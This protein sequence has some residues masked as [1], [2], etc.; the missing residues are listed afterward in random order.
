MVITGKEAPESGGASIERVDPGTSPENSDKKTDEASTGVGAETAA[1]NGVKTATPPRPGGQA[2]TTMTVPDGGWGAWVQVACSFVVMINTW[3]LINS[4]GV[5]Q[6][7]YETELLRGHSSS[8]ISWVGSLQG[9]L[10]LLLGIVSGPLF[11][12]GNFRRLMVGGLFL[13]VFG[14]FMTSI[15]KSYWQ[16]LLAQGVCVGV[17]SGLLF[18]PAA[19]I[20]SQYFARRR[21][22]ALG[23]Q[24]VGSPLAGILF[25]I[26]FS[27]LQPAVGFAWATRVI[28]FIL[29]GL[30]AIPVAFMRT[31]VPPPARKRAFFEPRALRDGPYMLFNVAGLCA[32]VG[33]YVPYFYIQLFAIRRG[34]ISAG[35]PAAG[36]SDEA[37]SSAYLVTVLNAGSILGRLLPNLAADRLGSVSMLAGT[38]LGA[39]VLA[40]AWLGVRRLGGLVAFALLFGFFNGG[41]T[42]LPPSAIAVLTPDLS[43]LG[44]RMGMTFLFTGSAVL[45]GTPIAGAILRSYS[46]AAWNGLIAYSG[47]TLMVGAAGFLAA[48]LTHVRRARAAKG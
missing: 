33:L 1:T 28:S 45:V 10:L 20:L 14:M 7:Y 39:A 12:A 43:R 4:F 25:P 40:L 38:T 35:D 37:S 21:A 30:S 3:G 8:A 32:Y 16:V 11:D 47:A 46:E 24:S 19:A 41:V 2:P 44:T 34:I 23:V 29:L 15:C 48:Q 9:A 22:F 5:F 6:T 42:S 36:S 13:I 31:R 17:G 26:I 18:L 27:R